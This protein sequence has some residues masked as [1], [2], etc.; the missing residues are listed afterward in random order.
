MSDDCVGGGAIENG[1]C[2]DGR[3]MLGLWGLWGLLGREEERYSHFRVESKER[4]HGTRNML[5]IRF[6]DT[7]SYDNYQIPLK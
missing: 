4:Q 7:S 3:V 5:L 2:G 1:F 6:D